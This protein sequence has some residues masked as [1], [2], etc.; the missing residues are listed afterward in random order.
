MRSVLRGWLIPLAAVLLCGPAG[1]AQAAEDTSAGAADQKIYNTLRDIINEGADLYNSGDQAGCYR[2]YEGALKTLRPLAHDDWGKAITDGL[3]EADRT[4]SVGERAF[5]LRRVIDRIRS[6]IHPKKGETAKPE[7]GTT[8]PPVTK[9]TETKPP[10]TETPK[11]T[12]LWERLGGEKGVTK[13]VDDLVAVAVKD[14]KVD[15]LRGGKYKPTADDVAKLKKEI[16]AWVSSKTGGPIP[17]TGENMK[18]AHK[19]MG[20]T[21]AQ[22]DA[23]AADLRE[24]LEKNR[25]KGDDLDA[26]MKAAAATR[27]DIVEKT[28]S[29]KKPDETRPKE[30]KPDEAGSNEKKN[31]KKP[32]NSK[33]NKDEKKPSS[34]NKP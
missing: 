3:A 19:G 21:D 8:R 1:A 29:E 20:I 27:K 13:V 18:D 12:T 7:T 9:P 4:P 31:E 32:S 15:F 5:V 6:S 25:V 11:P 22:F 33:D 2:L 17:Y 23:F 24:A 16:V 30:T 28:G 26:V 14:P 10:V 34:T